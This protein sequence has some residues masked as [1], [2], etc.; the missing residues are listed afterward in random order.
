MMSVGVSSLSAVGIRYSD[1]GVFELI[2]NPGA[3]RKWISTL[4]DLF[5]AISGV[6]MSP[7]VTEGALCP[8]WARA[9]VQLPTSS[10]TIFQSRIRKMLDL[11]S[12]TCYVTF[13]P[14][15]YVPG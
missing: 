13:A 12:S 15:L 7:T 10:T 1:L 6:A 8:A 2:W 11:L 14:V 9:K 3:T 4:P 5:W